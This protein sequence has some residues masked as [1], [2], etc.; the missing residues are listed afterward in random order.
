[1]QVA[2]QPR[3]NYANLVLAA[4]NSL[5]PHLNETFGPT[6]YNLQRSDRLIRVH[7]EKCEFSEGRRAQLYGTRGASA[8]ARK[9]G[10]ARERKV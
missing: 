2:A 1:M 6:L 7:V 5:K 8:V 4:A 10:A 9:R 3:L